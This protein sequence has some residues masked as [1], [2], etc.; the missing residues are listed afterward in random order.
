MLGFRARATDDVITVDRSEL[1]EA[2]WLS[3]AD[4]RRGAETEDVLLP[5]PVSIAWRLITDWLD[6]RPR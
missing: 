2:K 6:E 3:R 5:P 4:L 1:A